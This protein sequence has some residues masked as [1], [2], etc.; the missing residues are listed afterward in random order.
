MSQE[1][2]SPGMS[3]RFVIYRLVL[4]WKHSKEPLLI[5]ARDRRWIP[6]G[7]PINAGAGVIAK[8]GHLYARTLAVQFYDNSYLNSAGPLPAV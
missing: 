7:Q 3:Q 2:P 6:M 4:Y 8:Y 1:V 5:V